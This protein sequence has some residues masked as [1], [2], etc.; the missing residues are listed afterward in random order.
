MKRTKS[1][2]FLF[3]FVMTLVDGRD[4]IHSSSKAQSTV[5]QKSVSLLQSCPLSCEAFTC[6]GLFFF[7]PEA[8]TLTSAT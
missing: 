6:G 1:F 3:G 7:L 5:K 4:L 8:W 2:T